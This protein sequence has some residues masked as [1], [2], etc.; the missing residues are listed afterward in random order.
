MTS[1]ALGEQLPDPPSEE[2]GA[3]FKAMS[4]LDLENW[5]YRYACN[6]FARHP[7]GHNSEQIS[8]A[9]RSYDNA[10]MMAVTMLPDDGTVMEYAT[11]LAFL[12]LKEERPRL[13]FLN[14]LL[15]TDLIEPAQL[16][17]KATPP[18]AE[19]NLSEAQIAA[20]KTEQSVQTI[21][22][23]SLTL[24][25]TTDRFTADIWES[26]T[27]RKYQRRNRLSEY[28]LRAGKIAVVASVGFMALKQFR[29]K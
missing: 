19:V 22:L 11:A 9:S 3:A 2:I 6:V 26:A 14:W 21:D 20:M 27:A 23:F 18:E 5:N 28:G 4:E 13:R 8:E 16:F 29:K 15:D 17:I 10:F 24:S 12:R 7:S 1:S 25:K